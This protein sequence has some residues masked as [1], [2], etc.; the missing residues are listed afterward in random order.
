MDMSTATESGSIDPKTLTPLHY[1]GVLLAVISGLIHLRLGASFAPGP[2]G[3]SFLFAGVVFLAA[4]AAVVVDYRRPLLYQLGIPFTA[5]QVVLWYY[6]NFVAGPK[7]FPG[8]VGTLGGIDKLAQ[9]LFLLVL[10]LLLRRE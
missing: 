2:L 6:V 1:A 5:G 3:L 8:D 9:V 7:S 4:S 10:V